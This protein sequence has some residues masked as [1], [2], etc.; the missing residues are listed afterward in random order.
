VQFAAPIHELECTGAW[1]VIVLLRNV[2]GIKQ[3]NY[4]S[5][6]IGFPQYFNDIGHLIL[7]SHIDEARA[8]GTIDRL[9]LFVDFPVIR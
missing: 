9:A 2:F 7:A 4:R 3:L 5:T 6:R 8:V 1:G